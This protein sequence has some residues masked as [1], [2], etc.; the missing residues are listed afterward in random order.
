MLLSMVSHIN[1]LIILSEESNSLFN[2]S[3]LENALF[4]CA[5]MERVSLP[6]KKNL[7]GFYKL[8]P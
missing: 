2:K 4:F 5:N 6:K 1:N 3:Q 8:L 7:V